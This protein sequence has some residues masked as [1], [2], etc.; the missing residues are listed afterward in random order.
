MNK[1]DKINDVMTRAM[2][3]D[4]SVIDENTKTVRVVIA[5]ETPSIVADYSRRELIREVLL[6]D[7]TQIPSDDYLPMLDNHNRYESVSVTIKGFISN[8]RIENGELV[9]DYHV[10]ELA[11]KE[12]IMIKEGS[13]RA[14]SVGYKTY[15]D[16]SLYIKAGETAVVNNKQFVN[17]YD[18]KRGLV[19]RTVWTPKECSL[20]QVGADENAKMRGDNDDE[21]MIKLMAENEKLRREKEEINIKLNE[22]REKMDESKVKTEEEVRRDERNR[23]Q[24]IEAIAKKFGNN[25]RGGASELSE[26]AKTAIESGDSVDN[27]R[28]HVFNNYDDSRPL[29]KP[30][31]MVGMSE[32][33]TK[34]F[35]ITRALNAQIE[36]NWSKAGFEREVTEQLESNLRGIDGYNL[37][38]MPIPFEV[39]NKRA[40]ALMDAGTPGDGGYLVGTQHMGSEYIQLMRNKMVMAQ[41]GVK[42]IT[43]LRQNLVIPKQLTSPTLEWGTESF[44]PTTVKMTFGQVPL[45]PKEGKSKLD[46]SRKLFLQSIPSIDQLL[47]DDILQVAALG[48]D[49]A[50]LHG[51]GTNE[52][53]GIANTSGV[54]SVTGAGLDWSKVVEFETDVA[55]ANADV[56]ALKYITTP[57]VRGLLKT[58]EKISGYPLFLLGEDGKLNG[59]PLMPTN[60][61]DS[62]YMF[63]GDYS[64]VILA[65]WGTVEVLALPTAGTG[66]VVVTVFIAC[67]VGVKVAGAFSVASGIN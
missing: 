57:S 37:R 27:F 64:Q 52:P 31:G 48:K 47:M 17:N 65:E 41:A 35:S 62:G 32:N 45:T 2:I 5:T 55:S 11:E 67:D 20:V 54:G 24:E 46:Y 26:K 33:E 1:R 38:G 19:I 51:A 53:T 61:V 43:G 59:Y 36:K 49:R 14:V 28:A 60:Q 7:G 15:D 29:E 21:D 58:R 40:A 66:D 13:L 9:G 22:R 12:W 50:I 4:R 6:I 25:Y 16:K 3:F 42:I 34:K 30:V 23:V 63:F 8:I 18:D 56:N 44:D 39:M 10:S